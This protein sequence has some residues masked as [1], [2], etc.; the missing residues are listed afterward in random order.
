MLPDSITRVLTAFVDNELAPDKRQAV[1]RLLRRSEKARAFLLRL[2]NDARALRSLPPVPLGEDLS[3]K[4]LQQIAA[5]KVRLA[6]QSAHSVGTRPPVWL[7]L[8]TAAAVLLALGAGVYLYV[9]GTQTD[10]ATTGLPAR[11]ELVARTSSGDSNAPADKTAGTT[12]GKRAPERQLASARPVEKKT[13]VSDSMERVVA[14]TAPKPQDRDVPFV[15]PNR[16]TEIPKVAPVVVPLIVPLRELNRDTWQNQLVDEL[17]KIGVSWMELRCASPAA[18]VKQLQLLLEDRGFTFLIDEDAGAKIKLPVPNTSYAM[19]VE[20]LPATE[21]CA[22]LQQVV[23][24]SDSKLKDKLSVSPRFDKVSVRPMKAEDR[25]TFSKLAGIDPALLELRRAR[26]H[27]P[28]ESRS[29]ELQRQVQRR[30]IVVVEYES[31][32]RSL[33]HPLSEEVRRFF[34]RERDPNQALIIFVR[35]AKAR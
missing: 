22:V 35:D 32:S 34:A 21:I 12:T 16:P 2:H 10:N 25:N 14:T 31:G 24:E 17:N 15:S 3:E 9:L 13:V 11:S 8:A 6:R 30:A 28:A 33:A 19:Y 18:G 1:I 23:I 20:N 27:Q 26:E 29:G 4:V 7:G 5:Q